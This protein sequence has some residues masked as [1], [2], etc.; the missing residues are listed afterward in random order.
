MARAPLPIGSWGLI[1]TYP[2]KAPGESKPKR[3]RAMADYRDFDGV[4]RL[5]EASG[6]TATQASQN[7]RM[8]LQARTRASG[9]GELTGMSRF[10]DAAVM[11]AARVQEMVA[12]GRRSPGTFETYERQLRNHVLPAMGE[13]RLGE[14]STPLVDKVVTSIKRKVSPATGKSCRSVISGVLGLA[15]RYGAIAHNPVREIER[16]ESRPKRQPRALTAQERIEL[17]T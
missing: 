17:L 13:V 4:T 15:V 10:S 6:R 14:V 5:V 2:V 9:H 3:Y 7:L 12:D 8:R 16:I 1:R 11:W